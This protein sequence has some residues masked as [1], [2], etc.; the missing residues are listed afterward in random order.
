MP[1]RNVVVAQSGGPTCV[2]NNSLRGIIEA[3]REDANTFGTVLAGRFGIEG[4]LREELIDL[5]AT[6]SRAFRKCRPARPRRGGQSHFAPKTPQNRDS[7][8]PF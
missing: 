4:V 6:A 7:P 2:I 8:R 1:P 5:D 3:C